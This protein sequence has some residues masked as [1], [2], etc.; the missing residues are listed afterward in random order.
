MSAYSKADMP[1]STP[2]NPMDPREELPHG[3]AFPQASD[4]G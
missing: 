3:M 2:E 4:E 1:K